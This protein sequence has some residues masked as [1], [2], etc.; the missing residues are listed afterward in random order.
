MVMSVVPTPLP[1]GDVLIETT[2]CERFT[3][4]QAV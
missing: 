3:Q 4:I 2:R 1:G